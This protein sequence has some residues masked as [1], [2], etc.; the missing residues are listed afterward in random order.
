[1]HKPLAGRAILVTRPQAQ[2]VRLAALIEAEGGEALRFPTLAILP[3]RDPAKPAALLSGAGLAKHDLAVFV[4]PT[5]VQ[6]AFDMMANPWPAALP[7][8]AVGAGTARALEARGIAGVIVPAQGADSEAVAALPRLRDMAG[9]RVLIVRG[10]A[11]REWLGNTLAER[12]AQVDYAECYRRAAPDIPPAAI[13]GLAQ[14]WRGGGVDAVC[15]TSQE[16]LANLLK[17]FTADRTF[18]LATPLFAAHARI[19]EA[20]SR[21]GFQKIITSEP[22]DE[23]TLAA[24]E[25][26]FQP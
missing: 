14:R 10:E 19:A 16:A 6:A 8:A 25:A 17:L 3:P 4:S 22:G 9:Q 12:G 1:M 5:S 20:A 11:G 24:L 7:V 21:Q 15:I 13:A 26:F 2:A 18:V 23:A